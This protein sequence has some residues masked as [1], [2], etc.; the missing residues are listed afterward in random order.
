MIIFH[1]PMNKNFPSN[2]KKC[3][4]SRNEWPLFVLSRLQHN[5]TFDCQWAVWHPGTTVWQAA[6]SLLSRS[7]RR[8]TLTK[9]DD[10]PVRSPR[11]RGGN[12]TDSCLSGLLWP[13][14]KWWAPWIK[15]EL[16][17][18]SHPDGNG[19]SS[20][21]APLIWL[22]MT[23]MVMMTTAATMRGGASPAS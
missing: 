17:T 21:L 18:V 12:S 16:V 11:L 19:Q 22:M 8:G 6:S 1:V 9:A 7:D 4:T 2:V 20:I 15:D 10:T 13:V 5:L 3:R 14:D 23:V